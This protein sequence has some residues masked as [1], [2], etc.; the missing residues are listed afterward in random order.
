MGNDKIV[1]LIFIIMTTAIKLDPQKLLSQLA[2]AN[3][4]G[5]LQQFS[6]W[7][8]S[9]FSSPSKIENQSELVIIFG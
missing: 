2:D 7:K 6:F 5:C 4:S 9:E 1:Q 3:R 8:K